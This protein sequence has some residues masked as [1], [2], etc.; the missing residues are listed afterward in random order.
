MAINYFWNF[1]ILQNTLGE[2]AELIKNHVIADNLK[3]EQ[4]EILKAISLI[5]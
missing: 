2:L 3:T 5:L 1:K 4:K